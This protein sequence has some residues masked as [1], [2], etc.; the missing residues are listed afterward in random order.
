MCF[1]KVLITDLVRTVP[2]VRDGLVFL[3]LDWFSLDS[4][5]FSWIWISFLWIWIRTY[6]D[7]TNIIHKS[8]FCKLFGIVKNKLKKNT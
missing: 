3:D 2:Y 6:F 7:E 4:D 1:Q 8:T 5:W